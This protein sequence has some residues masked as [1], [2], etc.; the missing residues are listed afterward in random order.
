MNGPNKLECQITLG[1]TKLD[2]PA[3]ITLLRD[4]K[5]VLNCM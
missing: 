3:I 5:S 2:Q 1:F 4:N